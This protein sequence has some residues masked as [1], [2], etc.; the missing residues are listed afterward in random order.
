VYVTISGIKSF[1]DP[2]EP[3]SISDAD[4]LDAYNFA[5]GIIDSFCLTSFEDPGE[6]TVHYFNG[7]GRSTILAPEEAGPFQDV[8]L[9]EYYDG[10]AWNEWTEDFWILPHGI[11]L[12]GSMTK[13]TQNWRVTGRCYTVLEAWK[14]PLLERVTKLLAKWTLVPRDEPWGRTVQQ[15]SSEGLSYSYITPNQGHLTGNAE[16]DQL[17]LTLRVRTVG[18]G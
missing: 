3:D 8:T 11:V 18:V 15:V 14:N 16:I 5:K 1:C 6:D 9:I 2:D 10:D 12:D 4:A 17:L 13:G 7:T